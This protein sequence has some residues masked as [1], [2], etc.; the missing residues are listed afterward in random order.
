MVPEHLRFGGGAAETMLNPFVAVCLLVAII[1]I[2]TLPRA[3]AMIPFLAAFFFI[4]LT[5][6]VVLGGFHF[7][8][9]R[10][11]ILA[12][13]VR[14]ATFSGPSSQGEYPG[15]FNGVDRM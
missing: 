13:L 1:L 5:Q 9:A 8:V 2:M 12:G 4:P 6:V 3:K 10:I 7:T 14:R 15:R 11:L